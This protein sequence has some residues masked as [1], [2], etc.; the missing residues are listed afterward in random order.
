L[1][2]RED[3]EREKCG[4]TLTGLLPSPMLSVGAVSRNVGALGGGLSGSLPNP[5]LV[6]TLHGATSAISA[7]DLRGEADI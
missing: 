2:P 4:L 3:R 5:S 7:A 1:S 6:F